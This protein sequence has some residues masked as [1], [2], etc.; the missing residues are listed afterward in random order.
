MN[1]KVFFN[2][3][4]NKGYLKNM[5]QWTF[6]YYGSRRTIELSE[7]LKNLGFHLGTK[8]GIS[9]GM[10]D[11]WIPKEKHLTANISKKKKKK[12]YVYRQNAAA[13]PWEVNQTLTNVWRSISENFKSIIL[14][15]FDKEDPLNPLYLIAFSGA[16][17]NLVQ[18]QQLI[19]IR[20]LMI[21]PIG[22]VIQ[23]PIR[24]SFKEGLTLTEFVCLVTKFF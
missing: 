22:R 5:I 11:L 15:I 23:S 7:R 3:T 9:L 21:D 24:S 14:E 19:G 12:R 1:A 13:T 20:G 17:G 16:R 10:E 8:V 4:F 2:R 18:A 6:R